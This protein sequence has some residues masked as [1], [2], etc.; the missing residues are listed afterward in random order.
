MGQDRLESVPYLTQLGNWCRVYGAE[1]WEQARGRERSKRSMKQAANLSVILV[2]AMLVAACGGASPTAT[3]VPLPPTATQP[4][5]PPTNVPVP[6][7]LTPPPGPALDE[8]YRREDG[9][10][11]IRYPAGWH[12]EESGTMSAFMEDAKLLEEDPPSSPAII[13]DAGPIDSLISRGVAGAKDAQ[14]MIDG[15]AQARRDEG[16]D[17][18][19]GEIREAKIAGQTGLGA[20]LSWP[21]GE[22]EV[23][24]M[25]TALHMGDRGLMVHGYGEAEDMEAFKPL[26][27]A[28]IRSVTVFEPA[29]Q[30]TSV[31]PTAAPAG[32]V[33]FSDP[34]SVVQAVFDAAKSQEF[35]ALA[36]LCDPQGENDEDTAMICAITADHA[37]KDSFV[38]FFGKGQVAGEAIIDG[39]Q[40]QVNVLVGPDGSEAET[41]ILIQRDA[42]WY[43]LQF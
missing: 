20:T 27:V 41:I 22:K 25:V 24:D 43:L 16:K 31:P 3:P 26:Y 15:F 40:A 35:S 2:V 36:G 17:V 1:R 10:W 30:P 23:V 13:V 21:E 29:V 37:E 33:D 18:T 19:V 14:E 5:P 4:P 32:G 11:S 34:I 12:I 9:G 6:P 39:D 28:M 42:K 38:E 8:E 7:T